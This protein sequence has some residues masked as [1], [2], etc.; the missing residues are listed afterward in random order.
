MLQQPPASDSRKADRDRPTVAALKCAYSLMQQRIIS[1]PSDMMGVLLFG[2]E[3]SRFQEE[4]DHSKGLSYPHCYLLTDL[5][6]PAAQDVK[7]LRSLVEDDEESESLL[8]AST[9]E[10]SMANVLFCANQIFTTKAPNFSSRRLFLVTDNDSPH[11]KDKALRSAAAVRAKDL[12]DLGV[13]IE[14]FPISRQDHAFDR[15]VFYDD[16]IYSATL[17]DPDAPAPVTKASKASYSG[18]GIS[19]LQSLLSNIASKSSPRR[20]LFS[21]LPFEIGPG[22]KITVKG[23]IILKH[24]EPVR[25]SY[26][27]ISGEKPQIATGSSTLLADDTARTV[28]KV[29]VRKA[30]KFGGDTISFSKEEMAKMRN[31][32][33]PVLRIIGFKPLSMLP[34]WAAYRPSTF[35]YPSEEE[36]IGS[37]RVF[38][39]LQQKLVKDQKMA[40]AW[41]IPRR[42]AS[43]TLAAV[44]PGEE[45]LNDEGV[46]VMPPGLWVH[47]LPFADDVRQP[48]EVSVVR[49]PDDLIDKMR[50]VIQQLQLPKGVYD[51]HKYP[52]PSLQWF[53]RILQA[54]ALEEE[55]PEKPEDKTL[56]KYKQIHKRAGS[57]VLDWGEALESAYQVWAQQN[58]GTKTATGAAKRGT[59]TNNGAKTEAKKAKTDDVMTDEEMKKL[60]QKNGI[61]KLTVAVLKSWALSKGIKTAGKK[62]DLVDG[63]TSYFETKMET[64]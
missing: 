45:E 47:P 27:D 20:A 6:V 5:D 29:E 8:Q 58:A 22:L 46:Q 62:A 28:D 35:I 59:T 61:G 2:T 49:S 57:Y 41:F 11:A 10:V 42:N 51:A 18:D 52:N 25:S 13:V 50:V 37:T 12:Y 14:L 17:A 24:Q 15:S 30:Y 43:P 39:A 64:D 26:V 48:P 44:L 21:N 1:N 53:Y 19:L 32:G 34:T 23:Y 16:I 55:L 3:Q 7:R 36:V 33:D 56:P 4:D 63:I 31:F 54:M 9:E 60:H 38:S 40:L